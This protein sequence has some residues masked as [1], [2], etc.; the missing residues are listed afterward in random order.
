MAKLRFSLNVGTLYRTSI[1]KHLTNLK[2]D[3][4]YEDPTAKVELLE[5]KSFL[6][7]T[8]TF[9]VTD[10]KDYVVTACY[11]AVHNWAK[12]NGIACNL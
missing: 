8:F 11:R 10:A 2:A 12:E 3:L 4:L 7:S 1:R 9:V 6:E 5:S